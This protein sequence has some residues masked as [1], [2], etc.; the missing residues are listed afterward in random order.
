MDDFK[1]EFK[2]DGPP[3]GKGLGDKKKDDA[4]STP[5]GKGSVDARIDRLIG[6]LEQLRRELKKK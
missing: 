4:Q 3:F 1:K 2:K 5:A 6:E